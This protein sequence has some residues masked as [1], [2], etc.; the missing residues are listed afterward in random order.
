MEAGADRRAGRTSEPSRTRLPKAPVASTTDAQE[1]APFLPGI[2]NKAALIHPP[3]NHSLPPAIH[4]C[5]CCCRNTPTPTPSTPHRCHALC[6]R[7][8]AQHSTA[9][10]D[11]P[12]NVVLVA[13]LVQFQHLRSR[14]AKRVTCR[15]LKTRSTP[16]HQWRGKS[17]TSRQS[18]TSVTTGS[19]LAQEPECMRHARKACRHTSSC[20]YISHL[21]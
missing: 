1:A 20:V 19:D 10:L 8:L 9:L 2:A 17:S 7:Q 12:A 11:Q 21:T 16:P 4:L 13:Q 15:S 14:A 5:Y 3:T 6:I 18:Q